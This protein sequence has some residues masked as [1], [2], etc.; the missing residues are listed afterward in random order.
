MFRHG[1]N[2]LLRKQSLEYW[3]KKIFQTI[4]PNRPRLI[5]VTGLQKWLLLL[6]N[7]IL[8]TNDKIAENNRAAGGSDDNSKTSGQKKQQKVSTTLFITKNHSHTL[9]P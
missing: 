9:S 2:R 1:L 8:L 6:V 4:Q 7:M 5:A 3:K